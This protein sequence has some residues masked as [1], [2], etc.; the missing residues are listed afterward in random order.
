M[1]SGERR[2]KT[3]ERRGK[4]RNDQILFLM[5]SKAGRCGVCEKRYG[6]K[7]EHLIL[8]F[9]VA[10]QVDGLPPPRAA[11]T[12]STPKCSKTLPAAAVSGASIFRPAAASS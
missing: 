5:I 9:A 12:A 6:S 3:E 1:R 11:C 2:P 7:S 8:R 4:L 10:D